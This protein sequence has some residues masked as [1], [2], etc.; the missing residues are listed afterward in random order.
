M[1]GELLNGSCGCTAHRQV[2]TER[3]PQDMHTLRHLRATGDPS[4]VGLDHPVGEVSP[5]RS[6]EHP[7]PAQMAM[8]AQRRR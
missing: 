5:V 3:V 2:R 6:H 1:A 8:G 7:S 4:H